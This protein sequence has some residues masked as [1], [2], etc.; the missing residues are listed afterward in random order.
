MPSAEAGVEA[1]MH[2]YGIEGNWKSLGYQV[3]KSYPDIDKYVSA[4]ELE[5]KKF[6]VF[7]IP[8]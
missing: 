7:G 2:T 6:V 4:N 8:A 1:F 3:I 5:M